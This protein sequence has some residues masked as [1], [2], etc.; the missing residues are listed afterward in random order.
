MSL[1]SHVHQDDNR[2]AA[3]ALH[4]L[5]L[6]SIVLRRNIVT[7]RDQQQA[8]Q[9]LLEDNGEVVFEGNPASLS[10]VDSVVQTMLAAM[11]IPEV[12]PCWPPP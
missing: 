9:Q 2:E 3:S 12:R 11:G 8:A 1:C 10:D 6:V 7:I 4:R 5:L